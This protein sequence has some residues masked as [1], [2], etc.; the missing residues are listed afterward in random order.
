MKSLYVNKDRKITIPK[1]LR[2]RLEIKPRTKLFFYEEHNGIKIN[3]ITP[4]V[5]EA[6][7]GFMKTYGILLKALKKEKRI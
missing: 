5:I 6:N 3:P 4:K 1:F 2:E 7:I